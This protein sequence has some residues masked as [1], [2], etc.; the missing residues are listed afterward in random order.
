[1]GESGSE[2]GGEVGDIWENVKGGGGWVGGE[3]GE[4]WGEVG[5]RWEGTGEGVR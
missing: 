1:M 3:V 5:E 2:V 4:S